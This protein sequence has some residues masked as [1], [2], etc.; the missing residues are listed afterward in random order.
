M[1][2]TK[3]DRVVP[4]RPPSRA[5]GTEDARAFVGARLARAE[6]LGRAIANQIQEPADLAAAV[7]SALAELADP[8]YLTG[9]QFVAPG[10]GR[11]HGVR[12]PLMR[13]FGRGFRAVTR[14]DSPS[15]LLLVANQLL[16]EP[17]LEARWFAFGIL[18]QTL[19]R[20]RERT[21][22][23]IRRAERDAS[24][25]I[26]VDTLAHT[27][28]RGILDEP[29]RW[30]ELEQLVYAPSRWE[31]RLVG[32]TIATIPFVNRSAGRTPEIATRG[33]A[34]LAQLIGDAEP[35]VQK[36]LSW[37]YRS[38]A[39]V[40]VEATTTALEVEA[41][42]AAE[43]ADGH[44]AWVIRDALPKLEPT[45]AAAMRDALA[46]I[47]RRPGSA[48]TSS[49]SEIAARFA[50]LGLGRPPAEPPLT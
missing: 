26:T 43:T 12:S 25:W 13:A 10:I 27:V 40:D 23:L 20:D 44:R 33:L 29:Y 9:Q 17:E 32:S 34:L 18:E 36:A 7:G 48:S 4:V 35:D 38:M 19:P 31:R 3:V 16:G 30:A 47:R 37:A 41:E 46:G 5:S 49:A 1:T 11:T 22:Q 50:D 24:D 2:T 15:S 6:A 39:L 8:V 42:R 45:R 21:W 14:R 28:G